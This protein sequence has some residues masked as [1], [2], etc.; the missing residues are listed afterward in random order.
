M[1]KKKVW[2]PVQLPDGRWQ[3]RDRVTAGPCSRIAALI[4]AFR[5]F[6][7]ANAREYLFWEIAGVFWNH[8]ANS[9][10]HLLEKNS[11]SDRIIHHLEK[12][13]F[14]EKIVHYLAKWN[15]GQ[16]GTEKTRRRRK[17][18]YLAI[19]GCTSSGKSYV[20][21]AW[22]IVKWICDPADTLVLITTTTLKD[23]E[24]RV[25][26]AV[27]RLMDPIEGAL[28]V[29]GRPS[30][31][32][33]VYQNPETGKISKTAGIFLVAAERSK[34]KE[35]IGRFIGKKA[36]HIVLLADELGELSEAITHAGVTNLSKGGRDSFQMVGLSNPDSPF[37]AF[38]KWSEPKD[39][40]D[41]VDTMH[42]MEWVTKFNGR[43]IRLDAYDSPHL[44]KDKSYLPTQSDV[45][46]MKELLGPHSR[47]FY[48]M[49]RGIFFLGAIDGGVYSD[50]ELMKGGALSPAPSFKVTGR[51][52]G[53]DPSFTNGGDRTVLRILETGYTDAGRMV[54]RFLPAR[55]FQEDVNSPEPREY[56]LANWLKGQLQEFNIPLRRLAIDATGAGTPLASIIDNELGEGQCI[57][58]MFGS[59]A[60]DTRPNPRVR[61]V[62]SELYRDR[63]TEMWFVGKE[64]VRC[65]QLFELG[66]EVAKELTTRQYDQS[67]TGAGLRMKLE[68]KSEFKARTGGT[69]P[70]LADATF[71][72]LDAARSQLSFF[73]VEPIDDKNFSRL[74]AGGRPSLRAYDVAGRNDAAWLP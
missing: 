72:S 1:S 29:K 15:V 27:T 21:A 55:F 35:A 11:F 34:T 59:K 61:K 64:F 12:N 63:A 17:N 50:G 54:G 7:S 31:H 66:S 70:D 18:A 58:V 9:D 51:V 65:G 48:R 28:P 71:L 13:A 73:P 33:F 10:D 26:G 25:W 46:E 69:S 30:T 38:G 36:K 32:D 5:V 45:D 68:A 8:S 43:Y 2:D 67:K 74:H 57:R 23:A 52:A 4:W 16:K 44:H 22:A 24:Q 62:A 42:D 53:L 14:S 6:T 19:G 41:S 20:A 3:V 40:W 60:S 39:G 47:A 56:Q 37:D 49:W